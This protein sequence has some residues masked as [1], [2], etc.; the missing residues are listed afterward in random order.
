MREIS[1]RS[2]FE[3]SLGKI[4]QTLSRRKLSEKRVLEWFKV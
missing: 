3:V 4:F 1:G 2:C